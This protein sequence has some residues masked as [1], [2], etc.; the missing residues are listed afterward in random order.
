MAEQR[1]LVSLVIPAF[2]EEENIE[3]LYRA[4]APVLESL[5]DRYRFEI[6]FTDNHS[7][8]ATFEK[9]RTLSQRD[10]RVRVLR[11]SKNF[12]Y[13]KSIHAGYTHCRGDAAI[14]LDCD[15]Q[16]PPALL[17]EMLAR[18]EEGY[19][20]VY[21]VRRSRRES[22]RVHWQRKAFYRLLNWISSE[23]LPLDAGDFRLLDRR[24][25]EELRR[26]D[27]QGIYIRGVVAEMGFDQVGVEY[28]RGERL[29]GESKFPLRKMMGLAL[30]GL[31]NHSTIPLRLAAYFG[32]F[33]S[34]LTLLAA[35]AYALL[36]LL[37]RPEW[38]AGFTTIVLFLL[39]SLGINSLFLGILGEYLGR[40]YRQ[41]SSVQRPIIEAQIPPAADSRTGREADDR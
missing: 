15:L 5:A 26:I 6:L 18:W 23:P 33:V 40:L 24:I 14:Q 36:R 41:R 37:F 35:L 17:P 38:P 12:G 25:L 9:L 2:N 32:F 30:D 39:L 29:R 28:D 3:P 11:F 21:G 31:L 34:F 8:D 4:L 1:K 19:A 22:R 13:Q 27:P 20:V 10:P 16:D 7:T